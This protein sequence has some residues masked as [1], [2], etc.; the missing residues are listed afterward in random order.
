MVNGWLCLC[1]SFSF[2]QFVVLVVGG[3]DG[4]SWDCGC[5]FVREMIKVFLLLCRLEGKSCKKN[6]KL[7]INM[8]G[9]KTL[10]S[11]LADCRP[12]HSVGGERKRGE[13][14]QCSSVIRDKAFY[15]NMHQ[16]FQRECGWKGDSLL[17]VCLIPSSLS[18]S[19]GWWEDP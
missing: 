15:F 11:A 10:C 6:K 8:I 5:S 16:S 2:F 19:S 7:N 12:G 13:C 9:E 3:G 17:F 4:G 14:L 18:P 1:V